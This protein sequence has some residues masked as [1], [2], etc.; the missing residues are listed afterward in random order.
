MKSPME[1][2]NNFD[3]TMEM[4]VF[5]LGEHRFGINIARVREIVPLIGCKKVP[6]AHRSIVGIFELR[7]RVIPLVCLRS[8]LDV[9][10]DNTDD[11]KI[12]IC[13]F[14]D[15]EVGLWVDGVERIH[16]VPWKNIEAAG[17]IR[18]YSPMITGTVKTDDGI[19]TMLDYE[20]LIL[21]IAPSL[22][23][24]D[25]DAQNDPRI[26]SSRVWLVDDSPLMTE[27]LRR[28]LGN[29]GFSKLSSFSNGREVLDHL[30]AAGAGRQETESACDLL[31]T[32]IEMPLLDG[33]SLVR[34]LAAGP[35]RSFPVIMISSIDDPL[36]KLRGEAAGADVVLSK[37][38]ISRLPDIARRLISG[39]ESL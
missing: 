12:L 10:G 7:D 1:N 11:G 33:L 32:D 17:K 37:G 6:Y 5:S 31:V 25:A 34:R 22:I 15:L 16:T 4:V 27:Q 24:Q 21:E 26:E 20:G 35:G 38:E 9:P 23:P 3:R 28:V 19:I 30:E 18:N 2:R 39:G 13:R 29:A 14:L 8:W 36:E